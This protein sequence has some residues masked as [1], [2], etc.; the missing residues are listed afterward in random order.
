MTDM[1]LKQFARH[2]QRASVRSQAGQTRAMAEI[3]NLVKE[4]AKDLIG[5]E[6]VP[7]HGPFASWR[8]LADS[9]V[10]AKRA[11]GQ[12]GRI[13]A[14]DPLF[15]TG[16]LRSSI[17]ATHDHDTA[18]VG[19]DD[20]VMLYMEFGTKTIPPR[21]TIGLAMSMKADEATDILVKHILGP[22]T[23]T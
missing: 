2:L 1:S 15:G 21:S 23:D 6:N 18:V 14:T 5:H 12:T 10:E 16:E 3:A 13:S 7:G 19:S 4:T 11:K 20:P 8:P 22:I 9:T 17:E